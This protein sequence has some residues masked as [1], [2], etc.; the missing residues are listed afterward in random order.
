LKPS[1]SEALIRDTGILL[2]DYNPSYFKVSPITPIERE[3]EPMKPVYLYGEP[4][5]SLEQDDTI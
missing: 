2:K 3:P 1:P 5:D 4:K